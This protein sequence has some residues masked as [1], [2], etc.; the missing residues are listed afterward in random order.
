M[1][2]CLACWCGN[3][4]LVPFCPGYARCPA[5]ETLVSTEMPAPDISRVTDEERDFY[6]REYWF[7]Y[8][9]K[10]LGHPTIPNRARLDL[11]ERCLYWLRATLK[12][13][14]PPAR[15]LELG[16]GHGGFVAMLRWAGFDATG[17]EISPW[18]V[19]FARQ[20]F[21]VPML[22]G[23]VE[24]QAIAPAS[25]DLIALMDVLEHLRDPART[26]RHCLSLLKGD[27]I[28]L[29]QTPCYPEGSTY[30]QMLARSHQPLE[31]LQPQE[32][33][34]LFS[35]RSLREL[36]ARLGAAHVAFEPAL[37]AEYDMFPVASQAP[38]TVSPAPDIERAFDGSPKARMVR[39]LLDLD[40]ERGDLGRRYKES[41]ED[42]A[43][44]LEVIEEQGL[45]LGEVEAERNNL[46][47]EVAALLEQRDAVEADRAARLEVIEEQGRRLSEVEAERNNLRAEVAV[48][49]EQVQLLLSQLR[50]LQRSF[51]TIQR[52]RVYGLLR[53]LGR[54]EFLEQ[55]GDESSGGSSGVP[56]ERQSPSDEREGRAG[57][58]PVGGES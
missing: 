12:Y 44:R 41:E 31:I 8:Q 22:L 34:Y 39:A 10:R 58:K 30:E 5:C 26:M 11:P 16:S 56:L 54:W 33:L 6:G 45:R 17:L 23:P 38:L 20:T 49:Q 57:V 47:A 3:A 18:V 4:D 14:L 19:D 28:L 53:K 15:A 9:A 36:L 51:Q 52:T 29:I 40:A 50:M 42:R 2:D 55:M 43:M 46:R 1:T 7:S 21:H 35:R 48:Q 32:H 25:L 24:D 13:K 27:G 37:F